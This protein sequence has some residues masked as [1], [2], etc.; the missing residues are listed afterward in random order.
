[1]ATQRVCGALGILGT[2]CSCTSAERSWGQRG[3]AAHAGGMRSTR[4]GQAD[5]LE[6]TPALSARPTS[7]GSP[8]PY[9]VVA[10][11][12]L[13]QELGL[14]MHHRLDDELV[15]TGDV[16]EGATGTRVGQ[17]DQWLVAQRVLEGEVVSGW[18]VL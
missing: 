9:H 16:E 18:G 14:L 11:Q 13:L 10:G 4:L 6:G 17:L 7:F 12:Q 3:T 15:I 8:C 2:L 1:M 5:G